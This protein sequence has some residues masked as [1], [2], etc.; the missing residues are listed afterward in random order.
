MFANS[1]LFPHN[2]VQISKIFQMLTPNAGDHPKPRSDDIQQRRQ[3]SGMIRA[4]F[5]NRRSQVN[6]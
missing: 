3:L 2:A 5:E 1:S 4:Y 6:K